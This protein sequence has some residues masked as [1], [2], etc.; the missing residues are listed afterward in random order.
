MRAHILDALKDRQIKNV[1]FRV[2]TREVAPEDGFRK[3]EKTGRAFIEI[4]TLRAEPTEP[5]KD[6][7]EPE[8]ALPSWPSIAEMNPLHL[9]GEAD[10]TSA[11]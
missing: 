2:E 8:M 3:H 1:L 6:A 5:V 4:T 9:F 11:R 7:Q 10:E